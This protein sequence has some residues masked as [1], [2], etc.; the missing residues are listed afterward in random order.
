VFVFPLE[1]YEL[2]KFIKHN[3]CF[4]PPQHRSKEGGIK[5]GRQIDDNSSNDCNHM[6]NPLVQDRLKP[7]GSDSKMA[8]K[9]NKLEDPPVNGWAWTGV[10]SCAKAVAVSTIYSVVSTYFDLIFYD[11]RRCLHDRLRNNKKIRPFLVGFCPPPSLLCER[12]SPAAAPVCRSKLP[13]FRE[14]R[15]SLAPQVHFLM[16]LFP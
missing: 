6:L 12:S 4:W 7:G 5:S 16:L 15:F 8:D 10:C 2:V 9:W 13:K 14:R 11:R 1:L 3:N